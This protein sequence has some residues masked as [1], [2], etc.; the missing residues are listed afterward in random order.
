MDRGWL[1]TKGEAFYAFLEGAGV[2]GV[3]ACQGTDPLFVVGT[4]LAEGPHGRRIL[5]DRELHQF[6]RP[7]PEV[8]AA[9][10]PGMTG[11]I[12]TT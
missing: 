7:G 9:F 8:V 1:P 3:F 10:T 11:S 4:P 6:A 2:Q 5:F 12:T